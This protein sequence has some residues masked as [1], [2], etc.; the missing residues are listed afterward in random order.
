M[1]QAHSVQILFRRNGQNH[2]ALGKQLAEFVSR[3]G[4][5]YA[6]RLAVA[7]MNIACLFRKTFADVFGC[8]CHQPQGRY[9]RSG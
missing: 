8:A 6:S 5:A 7:S 3:G 9:Q 2:D 1:P 4:A